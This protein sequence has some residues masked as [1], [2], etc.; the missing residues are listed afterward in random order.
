LSIIELGIGLMTFGGLFVFFG[1]LFFFDR[2]LLAIGD[3]S[4]P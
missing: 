4:F 2:G 3:V 1:V